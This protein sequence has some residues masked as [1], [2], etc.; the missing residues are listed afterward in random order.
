ME[1]TLK[2]LGIFIILLFGLT[3]LFIFEGIPYWVQ[4]LDEKSSTIWNFG[5]IF[6]SVITII[7]YLYEG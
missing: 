2:V 6:I 4:N 5:I 1:I 3:L 7:I